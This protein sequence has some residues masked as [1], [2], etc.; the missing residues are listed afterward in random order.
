[1]GIAEDLNE[2]RSE[3]RLPPFDNDAEQSVLGGMML[4]VDACFECLTTLSEDDFYQGKHQLV[5]AAIRAVVGR[6][7][8]A[9]VLTVSAELAT[10]GVQAQAGGPTY[11]HVLT[12][13]TP[14]AANAGYYAQLV[15]DLAVKRRMIKAGTQIVQMGYATEG[16]PA[17]LASAAL[18]L[19]S[20]TV[21]VQR[22]PLRFVRDVLPDLVTK[23]EAGETFLPTPWRSVN[24]AIGGFRPGAVYVIAARPGEGKSMLAMQAALEM[25][26][27][28]LV[29]FSSLEMSDTELLSRLLS[30][31][32]DIFVGKFKD[33]RLEPRDWDVIGARQAEINSIGIAIDD[34][35]QVSAID[36]RAHAAKVA[37]EGKLVAIFVDYMQLMT[38]GSKLD[39]HLQVA[40]FSRQ[41]K[42]LAKD[43]DVPV[44]VL[45]QLNRKS[46]ERSTRRPVLSD[47]RESGAIEQDADV[48]L[49]LSRRPGIDCDDMS[50][51]IYLPRPGDG[52]KVPVDELIVDVAKNRHGRTG[53]CHL[54]WQGEFSRVVDWEDVR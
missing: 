21:A 17:T 47:L 49:L 51:G 3:S 20:A 27:H 36:V 34:S 19:V 7:E 4:S 35:T 38:S 5:F 32:L 14:T 53:E 12:S 37:R 44:I 33:N 10:T 23:L 15:R 54:R 9:D 24:N 29:S 52:V 11:V 28:G 39:R 40:E 48:V 42:I 46:E 41:L 26:R 16:D 6:G 43:F 22:K 30:D 1:M 45:S 2:A 25:S 8:P 18:E 31:R 13:V 50:H